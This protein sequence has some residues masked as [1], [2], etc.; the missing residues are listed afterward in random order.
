MIGANLAVGKQ[1]GLAVTT[2]FGAFAVG[3][4]ALFGLLDLAGVPLLTSGLSRV[5][6][7]SLDAGMV[8]TAAAAGGFLIRPIRKDVAALLPID[9]DNPVHELALVFSAL[10]LGLQVTSI[11]FTDVLATNSAQPPL[12][13]VDLFEDELPFLITALVGVGIFIRR[14]PIDGLRR[15]GVVVPA[16]WQIPLAVACA[17]VFFGLGQASDF[18]SHALTPG[19]AG[20]VDPTTQHVFGQLT[21]PWGIVAVALLP[22]ICEEI[23]FRG[24]LQPRLGLWVTALLF[25]SVHTEYGLSFDTLS[26]FLIAIGLGLIRRYTNTT[27]SAACHISYNLLVGIG[28][29]AALWNIALAAEAALIA[30]SAYAIWT[31]RRRRSTKPA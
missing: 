10:L 5:S 6:R 15:L 28:I 25:T 19:I 11:A 26:V 29:A 20:R 23:L 27:T 30:I 14:S 9:P 7:F 16:W 18:L 31:E 8:V 2:M 24:A 12:S 17:G 4:I 1:W 3:L 22:G 21:N 13:I